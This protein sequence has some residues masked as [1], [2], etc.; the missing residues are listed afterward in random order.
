MAHGNVK[1]VNPA[2]DETKMAPVGFSWTVLFFGVFPALFRL[3]WKNLAIMAGVIFGAAIITAGIGGW[4]AMVIFAFI[5]NDKMHLKGLLNK[6][7]KIKGYSGS[8]SLGDVE[9]AVGMS[10][11]KVMLNTEQN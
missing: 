6:G 5:Y 4:I 10:L 1:L 11:D 8:K 7:F 2:T 9:N 3:D